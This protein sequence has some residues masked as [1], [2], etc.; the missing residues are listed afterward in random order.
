M[1][2]QNRLEWV[3]EIVVSAL[4]ISILDTLLSD[5]GYQ[6]R[7]SVRSDHHVHIEWEQRPQAYYK[8]SLEERKYCKTGH[9][10]VLSYTSYR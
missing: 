10:H 5:S 7:F 1:Y 9:F 2:R 4:P 6:F 3:N 8:A